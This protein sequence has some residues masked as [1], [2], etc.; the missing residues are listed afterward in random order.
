MSKIL[1]IDDSKYM[2]ETLGDIL[3]KKDYEVFKASGGEEGVEIAREENP[4]V[5][6]IDTV[7]PG[8]D[9]FETCIRIKEIENNETKIIVMTGSIDA[10]DAGRATKAG[11]DDY[12][13]KT[14]D[15][16][17]LLVSVST[18]LK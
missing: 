13:A 6:I 14:R 5:V 12:C 2:L 7:M 4:D 3:E 8:I 11:A 18:L 16:S 15:Y 10:V 9:G 1:L 17:E